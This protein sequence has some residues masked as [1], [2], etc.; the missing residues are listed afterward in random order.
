M[1]KA[2]TEIQNIEIRSEEVQEIMGYIPH[3][4]VRWGISS[5]FLVVIIIIL[6]S[7]LF[8]YP[9]KISARIIL[10]SEMI[11]MVEVKPNE[12]GKVNIG[13]QVKIKLDIYP[14]HKYGI[15]RGKVSAITT[16]MNEKDRYTIQVILPSGLQTSYSVNNIDKKMKFFSNMQGNADIIIEDKRLIEKFIEPI[17]KILRY[18]E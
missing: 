6:G 7:Y 12:I 16:I 18:F 3:W 1:P 17:S 14:S 13:Q 9:D 10:T 8:K 4:I 15:I 5:I 11:G 2:N